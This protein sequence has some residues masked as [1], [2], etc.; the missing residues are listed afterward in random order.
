MA[1]EGAVQSVARTF[2]VLDAIADAGGSAGLTQIAS[3]AG[4]PESTT[5]RLMAT[6]TTLG[7]VRRLEDR[8]YGLGSRLVRLGS[9]AAPVVGAVV[10]PTLAKL[11]DDLG[12]SANLAMLVGAQAEYVAQVPSRHAMRLF[13]EVGRRVD[14]HCTGVGKA[15]L[16]ALDAAAVTAIIDGS[17]LPART[18][19]TIVDR[20]TMGAELAGIRARG[21]AMDEQE[22]ELGVRCVA[23]PIPLPD[24]GVFA[25]SVSGPLQRM[26]DDLVARAV[27]ALQAAASE[28][29]RAVA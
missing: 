7:V 6:L 11:V 16:S 8:R 20:A 3:R 9:A 17:G 23:V 29:S 12:E 5:H 27:P 15:M 25:V 28:I 1:A 22:Q 2:A 4:L 21:Y 13:T 10:R 24:G 18:A 14:L 19:H 26:T